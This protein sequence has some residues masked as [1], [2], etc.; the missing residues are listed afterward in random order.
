METSPNN[1][2]DEVY[3]KRIKT[4]VGDPIRNFDSMDIYGFLLKSK[5]EPE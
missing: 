4:I 5:K 2:T 1:E 3:L